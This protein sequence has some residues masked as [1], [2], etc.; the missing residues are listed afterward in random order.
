MA[1]TQIKYCIIILTIFNFKLSKANEN[2]FLT[3]LEEKFENKLSDLSF[4]AAKWLENFNDKHLGESEIG[5]L[6]HYKDL[7]PKIASEARDGKSMKKMGMAMLPLVFH[8]GATSTWMMLTSLMAAKSVAIGLALLVF[9]I[10]VSSAKVASFFTTLKAKHNHHEY[11]WS[12]PMEHHGSYYSDWNSYSPEISNTPP[13]YK[14]IPTYKS[15][16]PYEVAEYIDE[17]KPHS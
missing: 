1:S 15:H 6:L 16:E 11:S 2:N 14:T 9:K 12:P 4:F 3:L 5:R 7:K 8:V 10:A 17:P 13:T